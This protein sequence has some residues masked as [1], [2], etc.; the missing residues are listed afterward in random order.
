MLNGK[1]QYGAAFRAALAQT[2]KDHSDDRAAKDAAHAVASIVSM[3]A[4]GK[5]ETSDLRKIDAATTA[6]LK[7]VSI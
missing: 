4:E 3:I 6:A 2:R 5:L 7:A 1:Q